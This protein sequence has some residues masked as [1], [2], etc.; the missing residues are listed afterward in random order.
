[1]SRPGLL[2]HP[3]RRKRRWQSVFSPVEGQR[4]ARFFAGLPE[5]IRTKWDA[6]ATWGQIRG[7]LL[8]AVRPLFGMLDDIE[9]LFTGGRIIDR[10]DRGWVFPA[11]GVGWC[12]IELMRVRRTAQG[13]CIRI[14]IYL[15]WLKFVEEENF[16][17]SPCH[18]Y[19]NRKR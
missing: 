9:L 5:G 1:M 2:A 13:N 16:F 6:I 17:N 15:S 7:F 19:T 12:G 10:T 11:G 14:Y 4:G 18:I 3:R 8:S